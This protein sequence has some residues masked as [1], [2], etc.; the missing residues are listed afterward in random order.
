MSFLQASKGEEA[1]LKEVKD[2]LA[3]H[4][5]LLCTIFMHNAARYA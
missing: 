2:A 5:E 1:A 3:V 4:A